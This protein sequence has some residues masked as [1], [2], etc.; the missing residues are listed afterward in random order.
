MP[1][2]STDRP[3]RTGFTTGACATAAA[4]GALIALIERRA[5]ERVTIRL[6]R[7]ATLEFVVGV[8]GA[9]LASS[10]IA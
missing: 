9:C 1:N 4:K 7:G 2:P 3:L 6:P 8:E 10:G 5:G